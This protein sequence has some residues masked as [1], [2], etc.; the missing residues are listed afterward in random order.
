MTAVLLLDSDWN[1]QSLEILEFL[2]F[3]CFL[4]Y[5][6]ETFL[7]ERQQIQSHFEVFSRIFRNFFHFPPACDLLQGHIVNVLDCPAALI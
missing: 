1:V 2:E 5:P 7:N 4:K 3:F 6:F